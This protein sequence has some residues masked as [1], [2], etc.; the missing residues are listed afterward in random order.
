MPNLPAAARSPGMTR[1]S[2]A[3]TRSSSPPI[4]TM[5]TT[6]VSPEAPGSL[7]IP[8]TPVAGT[9]SPRPTSSRPEHLMADR[10]QEAQSPAAAGGTPRVAVIGAGYWG[11]NLVRN[12]AALGAL[13]AIVDSN[14]ET[15]AKM[16]AAHGGHHAGLD[17]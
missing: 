7:S 11:K 6:R 17:E 14:A 5:S 10:A 4:M 13:A 15:A 2:R 16:V 8:V 12:F 1:R 9:A 3:T